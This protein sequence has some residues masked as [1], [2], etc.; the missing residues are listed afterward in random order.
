MTSPRSTSIPKAMQASF[1]AVVAL[2]DPF[3]HD[4]LNNEYRDL[5]RAIAAALCR[6]RPSPLAAGKPRT[7]HGPDLDALELR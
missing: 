6:K 7:P 4:H 5:A 1:D 2:T 3:C